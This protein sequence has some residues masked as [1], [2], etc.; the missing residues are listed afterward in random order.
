MTCFLPIT[1]DLENLTNDVPMTFAGSRKII[2]CKSSKSERRLSESGNMLNNG[3]WYL[4]GWYHVSQTLKGLQKNQEAQVRLLAAGYLF[5]QCK[6]IRSR[7]IYGDEICCRDGGFQ[8]GIC[9]FL[10]HRHG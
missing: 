10:D 6:F 7:S 8:P 9:C 5:G 1:L 4:V 2:V 3:D